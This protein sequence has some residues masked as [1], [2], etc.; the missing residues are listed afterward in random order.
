MVLPSLLPWIDIKMTEGTTI[1]YSRWFERNTLLLLN[2]QFVITLMYGLL[3]TWAFLEVLA[4]LTLTYL[5]GCETADLYG[6]PT[7]P[8]YHNH[9]TD[10][11]KM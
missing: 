11:E 5:M 1:S 9:G 7:L 8:A 6:L 2:M 4:V 10:I 3:T